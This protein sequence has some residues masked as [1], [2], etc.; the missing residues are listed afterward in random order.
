V[1]FLEIHLCDHEN[2]VKNVAPTVFSERSFFS[3]K[4]KNP[5]NPAE[6]DFAGLYSSGFYVDFHEIR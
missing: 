5:L 6:V 2:S 4:V 3:E 1:E